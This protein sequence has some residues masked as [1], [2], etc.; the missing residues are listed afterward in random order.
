MSRSARRFS[1]A[2]IAAGALVG[3]AA[4]PAAADDNDRGYGRSNSNSGVVL[5]EIQYESPGTDYGTNRSLNGE[6]VTVTNT[7]YRTVDLSGWT[8]SDESRRT[9]RFDMSLAG[10]SSVRVHTGY[11]RDNRHD[12]YQDLRHYVWDDS[13]TATL[14]N[15]DGYRVDSKSWGHGRDD[16]HRRHDHRRHEDRRHEDRDHDG[17]GHRDRDHKDRDRKDRDRKDRDHRDRDRK[18][19]DHRDRDRKD[20]DHDGWGHKDRDH[21]D[22]DHKDRDHRD[23]DHKDRDH[24]DRDHKDRDHKD[25][26][27]DGRR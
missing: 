4:L 3:A 12:V 14:R 17:W 10:R 8:L 11:G 15:E 26:D 7:S 16:D 1:A 20:R 21:R 18:D 22:R 2:V 25:R 24:K 5:G 19:R 9:Y 13:D 23:R 27:H 6:W